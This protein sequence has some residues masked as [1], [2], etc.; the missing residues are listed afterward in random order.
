MTLGHLTQLAEVPA[1]EAGCSGFESLGGHVPYKDIEK[2]RAVSR[3]HYHENKKSYLD[4]NKEAKK[5]GQELLRK[6]KEENPCTDCGEFYPYYVMDYDHLDGSTK[7]ANV[8]HVLT[9]S[10][11]AAMLREIEKC[12][13]VC[14]NC[15]RV[16]THRR[17]SEG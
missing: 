5:K 12:E 4:R 13:L 17:L 14:A 9:K 1:S 11:V 15:H 16:R 3:A 7:I 2:R 10:G 8:S 6:M